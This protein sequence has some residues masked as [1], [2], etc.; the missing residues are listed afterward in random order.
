MYVSDINPGQHACFSE[1]KQEEIEGKDSK[2]LIIHCHI[3]L[4]HAHMFIFLLAKTYQENILYILL[5]LGLLFFSVT[6]YNI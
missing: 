3:I 6:V 2:P 5:L 1:C 4:T